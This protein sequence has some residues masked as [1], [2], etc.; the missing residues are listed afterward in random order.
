M[1]RAERSQQLDK[2]AVQRSYRKEADQKSQ[3]LLR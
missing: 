2:E 1:R 3:E